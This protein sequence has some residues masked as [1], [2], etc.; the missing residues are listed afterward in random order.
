MRAEI[1]ESEW[2]EIDSGDCAVTFSYSVDGNNRISKTAK[3]I[4]AECG[5]FPLSA[6]NESGQLEF[7]NADSLMDEHFDIQTG[8]TLL[9]FR[10]MR[11]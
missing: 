9:A 11:Q 3:S 8:D 7:A 10:W 6:F 1:T 5:N 4:T 2:K